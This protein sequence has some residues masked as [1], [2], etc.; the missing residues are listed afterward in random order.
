MT[1][2]GGLARLREAG[3]TQHRG[4]DAGVVLRIIL[5][6]CLMSQGGDRCFLQNV[7]P[8]PRGGCSPAG[9]AASL[10]WKVICVGETC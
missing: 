2:I 6:T 8:W 3:S 5:Y 9:D 4:G 10:A 7:G 1:G